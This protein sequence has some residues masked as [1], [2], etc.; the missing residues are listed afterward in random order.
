MI[1]I[2]RQN[3]RQIITS[4]VD[5]RIGADNGG[6]GGGGGALDQIY[7]T[8]LF[9][10]IG[11]FTAKNDKVLSACEEWDYGTHYLYHSTSPSFS[12]FFNIGRFSHMGRDS[13]TKSNAGLTFGQ[14]L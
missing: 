2:R 11:S 7:N 13:P 14:R 10:N 4:E 12:C 1:D 9:Y 5:P 3:R 6:G 8:I